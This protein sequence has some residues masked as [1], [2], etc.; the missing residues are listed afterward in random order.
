METKN[1][2]TTEKNSTHYTQFQR[3]KMGGGKV[4]KINQP[5][6]KELEIL[7]CLSQDYM[8]IKQIAI[9]RNCTDKAV[10]KIIKNLKKKGLINIAQKSTIGRHSTLSGKTERLKKV[11]KQGGHFSTPNHQPTI[12]TSTTTSADAPHL[13]RLHGQQFI[14]KILWHDQRYTDKPGTI[15]NIDGNKIKCNKDSI[16]IYSNQSFFGADPQ[17]A[18]AKS[19]EYWEQFITRIEHDL[20]ILLI[21]ARSQNIRQV[22]AEYAETGN[23]L[24]Q[25]CE[26]K[27]YKIRIYTTDDNKLW[28][29]IDNSFNLHEAETQHPQTSKQ[30][31]DKLSSFFNDI[32]E[33]SPINLSDFIT[34]LEQQATILIETEKEMKEITKGLHVVVQAL[35]RLVPAQNRVSEEKS[36]QSI[37]G[38]G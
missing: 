36:K 10:Y 15:I 16:E 38:Y 17:E 30:D 7:N 21:K 18:T 2:Q 4:G 23:E 22:K 20:K 29:T 13:I 32:R 24:A 8:T 31:M 26:H 6:K 34:A 35:E 11:E 37:E 12:G 27:G 25:E 3:L 28:F 14:I 9:E 19:I 5:T 1:S 33:K